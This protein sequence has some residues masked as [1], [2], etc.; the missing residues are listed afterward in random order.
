MQK[1]P[2]PQPAI[3]SGSAQ[4][5]HATQRQTP[6]QHHTVADGL[7]TP[8]VNAY[9]NSRSAHPAHLNLLHLQRALGNRAVGQ[10][11]Q[12]KL[13]ISHPGDPYEQEADRVADTVMRMT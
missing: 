10:L 12:A 13:T 9:D 7:L 11:I 2:S 3:K 4:R 1:T 8:G 5:P 6:T